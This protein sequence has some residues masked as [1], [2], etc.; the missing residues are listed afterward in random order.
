MTLARITPA[1]PPIMYE[2]MTA[3]RDR[4]PE[5]TFGAMKKYYVWR[6]VPARHVGNY[7]LSYMHAES[8]HN[9]YLL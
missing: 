2:F 4:N 8:F 9:R 1:M 5:V 7:L 3:T 6:Y